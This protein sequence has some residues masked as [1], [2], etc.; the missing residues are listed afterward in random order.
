MPSAIFDTL[1]RPV[2][3]HFATFDTLATPQLLEEV[4]YLNKF[5]FFI[6]VGHLF[7]FTIIKQRSSTYKSPGR[8]FNQTDDRIQGEYQSLYT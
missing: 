5:S 8:L 3:V 4:M 2:L 1:V 6:W 7:Q